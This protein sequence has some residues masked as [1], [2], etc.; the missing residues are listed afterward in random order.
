MIVMLVRNKE[1]YL[2][3]TLTQ[4][5]EL[6]YPKERLALW[7]HS[8]HNEDRSAELLA[9]WL[10]E[11]RP[12][13][14]SVHAV[15]NT[16]SPPLR[17]D[18]SSAIDMS[19]GRYR[20]VI[21]LKEDA[22][23]AARRIW[24]DFVWFLD[25]DVILHE[26][27]VLRQLIEMRKPVVAP[28]LRTHGA[29]SNFWAGMDDN[30]YYRRTEEYGQIYGS[31][32][33]GCFSVP[34]VHSCVLVNLLSTRSDGLTF[35]REKLPAPIGPTSDDVIT[36]ALSARQAGMEMHVCNQ[37][38]FGQM[39]IPLRSPEVL[40][41][42]WLN[43]VNIKLEMMVDHPPPPVASVLRPFVPDPPEK[44]KLG[45]DHIYMIG[46]AR[47]PDRRRR[48]LLAFDELG[49]DAETVDAVDG[50]QLNDSALA[51]LGVAMLRDYRDPI[52]D[53]RLTFGEIGCFLSHHRVWSD[54]VAHGYERIIVFEDDLRFASYFHYRLERLMAEVDALNL[55]W[56]LIYLG[57]KI[58]RTDEEWVAGAQRLVHPSYT[59]W[60]LAYAL[61]RRGAE[62]L[63]KEE[64][65]GKMIAVDEYLPIMFGQHPNTGWAAQF[66]GAGSLLAYSASPLLVTPIKYTG[67]PGYV[68]DT[69]DAGTIGA[70]LEGTCSVDGCPTPAN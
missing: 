42:E 36:F 23:T 61:T 25:A 62:K 69:E 39:P 46:L 51:E 59:Y 38:D 47:R 6:D 45:F 56:D 65:L 26:A 14:R 20:D 29:Y 40:G 34:M 27:A 48:M 10:A 5:S 30:F 1:P 33:R 15:L 4:L 55:D 24:A 19:E 60:T 50:R 11:Y 3:Y 13:Y 43:I 22:L 17:P 58:M 32:K 49:I 8:D 31:K 18:E 7:I 64:P 12:L 70:E 53:R 57:R 52:N 2:P 16:T 67:E 44:T 63:L 37:R 66:S 35:V 54:M 41:K 21:K 28:M 68:S 9:A